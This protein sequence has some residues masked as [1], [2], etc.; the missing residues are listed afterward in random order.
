V[1]FDLSTLP[2]GT[3]PAKVS[4]AYLRLYVNKVSTAGAFFV[5]AATAGWAE[6]SVTGLTGVVAG[7][8]VAG[9]ISVSTANVYISIPVTAQVQAWLS[10]APNNG[11]ILTANPST[12]SVSFDTKESTSTS[13]PAVLEI[14]LIGQTGATGAQGPAGPAG[15]TGPT[16]PTGPNGPQGDAGPQGAFGTAGAAGAVGPVGPAGPQGPTGVKGATGAT[17]TAGAA[18]PKGP[19]GPAGPTGVQGPTGP[20]G[21]A[22]NTGPIG[23]TG[24]QGPT[25]T[26]GGQGPA[27]PAGLILNSYTNSSVISPG[28]FAAGVTQ[29]TILLNNTSAN[30]VNVTM[31][32]ATTAGMDLVVVLS[33]FSF[34]G[35]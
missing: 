31:P 17:G 11:L 4:S 24:L 26:T 12:T 29:N 13:H 27:G 20:T 23:P 5:N 33:D 8:F 3:T 1:Q 35:K 34:N 28:T 7:A 2:P 16:G 9:P 18:G 32:A 25:G 30:P 15:P 6:S 22:G 10:G 14:D 19:I 21:P